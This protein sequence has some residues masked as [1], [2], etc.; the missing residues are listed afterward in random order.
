MSS[1]RAIDPVPLLIAVG[2][3]PVWTV[4]S[5]QTPCVCYPPFPPS[6]HIPTRCE[7]VCFISKDSVLLRLVGNNRFSVVSVPLE[8]NDRHAPVPVSARTVAVS[9]PP[10]SLDAQGSLHMTPCLP[11]KRREPLLRGFFLVV[12]SVV[13]C[14]WLFWRFFFSPLTS[15][16]LN[17]QRNLIDPLGLDLSLFFVFIFCRTTLV[18]RVQ[19]H[20]FLQGIS[21]PPFGASL[22]PTWPP[23]RKRVACSRRIVLGCF[24]EPFSFVVVELK[25]RTDL[26]QLT[27]RSTRLIRCV[28]I[29]RA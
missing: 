3:F 20:V 10:S 8:S 23:A 27:L 17:N 13:V 24:L 2:Y 28:P 15:A 9:L 12:L 22:T 5:V 7:R 21:L 29:C 11:L 16:F 4:D 1:R 26:N 18:R 25:P 6:L 14:C 19:V